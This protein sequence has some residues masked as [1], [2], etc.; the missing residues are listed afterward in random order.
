MKNDKT[1]YSFFNN[2]LVLAYGLEDFITPTQAKIFYLN[3]VEV[4]FPTNSPD[5]I[6]II[7]G[8]KNIAEIKFKKE[9]G[10]LSRDE[11]L[12]IIIV[13]DNNRERYDKEIN[14]ELFKSRMDV[15]RRVIQK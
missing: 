7:K 15:L 8:I 10:E 13:I 1:W 2:Y 6:I 3:N 4:Y 11:I 9:I 12:E 5:T 14:P